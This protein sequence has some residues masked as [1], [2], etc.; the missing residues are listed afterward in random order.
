[1]PRSRPYTLLIALGFSPAVLTETVFA[2]FEQ[3]R[4]GPSRVPSSVH[5]ITTGKAEPFVRALL[6]GD[7]NARKPKTLKPF[8]NAADRWTPFCTE[9]LGLPKP[10]DLHIHVPTVGD[11]P[12][13]DVLD[14]GDDTRFANLCYERVRSLTEDDALPLVGSIAGGRKTMSA[15]LMTAFCMYGRPEDTLTHILVS[16]ETLEE[17]RDFFY[18]VP[19]TPEYGRQT[20]ALHLV[21]IPFPTLRS[22]LEDDVLSAIDATDEHFEALRDVLQPQT[23]SRREVKSVRLEVREREKPTLV[24]RD[25]ADQTQA[26]CTLTPKH[27]ATLVAFAEERSRHGEAVPAPTFYETRRREVDQNRQVMA[28]HC[29][30]VDRLEPWSSSKDVSQAL[31]DLRARLRAEPLAERMFA[32]EGV[33]SKP[34]R[35]DWPGPPPPL[36]VASEFATGPIETEEDKQNFGWPFQ[37]ISA[38]SL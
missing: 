16:D 34:R 17:S 18:P 26:T 11:N 31:S 9:V 8:E 3:D 32:V 29:G 25:A 4:I 37:H 10:I 24:F 30:L 15:H 14:R 35:Y 2:I 21:R 23:V 1:M 5:V 27:A 19:G 28:T 20:M 6:L 12:L 33:S 7:T 36:T 13:E 38:H 22:V